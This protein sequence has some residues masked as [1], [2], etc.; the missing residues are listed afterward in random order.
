MAD[1]YKTDHYDLKQGKDL[2]VVHRQGQGPVPHSA[3][4]K[5]GWSTQRGLAVLVSAAPEPALP[6]GL[7]C[8]LDTASPAETTVHGSQG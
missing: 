6:Q 4:K 3:W 8:Q 7:L 2:G 1:G 5:L